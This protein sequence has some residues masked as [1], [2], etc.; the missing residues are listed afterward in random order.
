MVKSLVSIV[1]PVYQC[2]TSIKRTIKALLAQTYRPLEII[3]VDDGSTDM[4]GIICDFYAEKYK[5][6]RAFHQRHQGVSAARNLG[7]REA[8]GKYIQFTDA[9]DEPMPKLIEELVKTLEA[10]QADMAVCNYE[11]IEANQIRKECLSKEH[12]VLY[13]NRDDDVYFILQKNVLSVTWNKLYQKEKIRHLYDETLILCED[14]V[15]CT[16]YFMDNHSV[17]LCPCILYKYHNETKKCNPRVQRIFGYPGIKK[18]LYCNW[19]LAGNIKDRVKRENCFQHIYKVFFYGVYTY[20]FE[21]AGRLGYKNPIAKYAVNTVIKDK[22]Y[23]K[24]IRKIKH[25][26][27]KERLYRF[28]CVQQSFDLLSVELYVREKLLFLFR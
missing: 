13:R 10:K 4:S 28:A 12:K 14:S 24:V 1:V 15:F 5:E 22:L 20:I 11:I 17:A 2:E 8:N 26:N 3:L 16:R 21:E 9:D 27:M 19:K 25:A 6:I 7:I 18:Y 23:Q